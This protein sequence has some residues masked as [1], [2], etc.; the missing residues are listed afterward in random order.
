[1]AGGL[2][3]LSAMT[4]AQFIEYQP[5]DLVEVGSAALVGN[6]I[7]LG[8]GYSLRTDDGTSRAMAQHV[9][10]IGLA[11]TAAFLAPHTR[12]RL[13]D[14]S[15]LTLGAALGA[16]LGAWMPGA[17][18]ADTRE[19]AGGA[20]TGAGIGLVASAVAA[21][22]IDVEPAEA[23]A[24]AGGATTLAL[25]G[26]GSMRL[27]LDNVSSKTQTQAALATTA[28][29]GAGLGIAAPYLHLERIDLVAVPFG[30]V[31]GALQG[32]W[33]PRIIPGAHD[34]RR[35]WSGIQ[36]GVPAGALA[37]ALASPHLDRDGWD[38]TEVALATGLGNA[39][40]LSGGCLLS[41]GDCFD[42]DNAAPA[43]GAELI[44]LGTM[45]LALAVAPAT[46]FERRDVFYAGTAAT[47]GALYGARLTDMVHDRAG[48]GALLGGSIGLLGGAALS[49]WLHL[50]SAD[51]LETLTATTM[52][53]A[54]ADGVTGLISDE[55][56]NSETR[57]L[58]SSIAGLAAFGGMSLLAGSTEYQSSDWGLMALTTGVGTWTGSR[59]M[60]F[61]EEPTLGDYGR[62]ALLGGILGGF[63]GMMMAQYLQVDTST[64]LFATGGA[65]AGNVLGWSL[66]QMGNTESSRSQLGALGMS[67][68]GVGLAVGGG[69]LGDRLSI[70][71]SNAGMV[72]L[73]GAM[74][75]WHGAWLPRTWNTDDV[76]DVGR[77]Q[78]LG[79][80]LLGAGVGLITGAVYANNLEY[81]PGDIAEST[82]AWAAANSF[83]A[84]LGLVVS[85]DHRVAVGLMEG[86]GILG[87]LLMAGAAPHTEFDGNDWVL[88]AL[89]TSLGVWQGVGTARLFNEEDPENLA[90]TI[91]M[92]TA[93]GG[94]AGAL[95]S[96]QLELTLAETLSGFSGTLWG[97]WLGAW[98]AV[99][100]E[101][102][103][104][105]DVA[106]VSA[107]GSDIG[108]LLSSI[109]VS[110][111][112]D[113]PPE[114]VGYINLFG[115]GGALAGAAI[116]VLLPGD[117]NIQTGTLYGTTAALVAGT[118]LTYIFGWG[119]T[120]PATAESV[121]AATSST[122][123]WGLPDWL[124]E[125]EMAMPT[126]GP[127]PPPDPDWPQ[128]E[129]GFYIGVQGIYR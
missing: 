119:A 94:V 22:W 110:R 101:D 106:G 93:A 3:L 21:Q 47:V 48:E 14:A 29:L 118:T 67:V 61:V 86:F 24:I 58:S 79:G 125:V 39:I 52:T 2:G 25:I 23:A 124:P 129:A 4:L 19:R 55:S 36:F 74:G 33:L 9:A 40:G 84:G 27:V 13:A 114:Q 90:G 92:T 43:W 78:L 73:V 50:D 100:Y 60:T 12:Y 128:P 1:M 123:S 112:V 44:G 71:A 32:A 83:G 97:A 56:F 116:G 26:D 87:T 15:T 42:A 103:L 68:G 31:I 102:S 91:M 69:L 99:V 17:W 104:G 20:L 37:F 105:A 35:M 18:D 108:L 117:K 49:Q 122:A 62:G 126:M 7:G 64:L 77:N 34:S 28:A 59:L 16:G 72:S 63:S 89:A 98:T 5:A 51:T 41:N 127:P 95:L 46:S 88:G 45:G 75:A 115:L 10:G 85:D 76:D 111:L 120:S 107:V 113:M 65:V 121:S 66:G 57:V 38:Y 8:I 81:S 54:F 30:A 70:G 96:Q 82:M 11:T 6:L 109:A 53:W 80:G